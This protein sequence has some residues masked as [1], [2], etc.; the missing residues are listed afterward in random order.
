MN[1]KKSTTFL[2]L[3]L[4]FTFSCKSYVVPDKIKN[5]FTT[6]GPLCSDIFQVIIIKNPDKGIKTQAEQRES[7][8][9]STRNNIQT[10]CV[11][12]MFQFYTEQKK[13]SETQLSIETVS[14]IRE[15]FTSIAEDYV[16]EQEY[17]LEDNSA[18]LII[19][20]YQN[21]IINKILNY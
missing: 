11:N 10:E 1:Y 3:L 20:I 9:N 16:I 17:Y 2:F 6:R 18:V 4:L 12:Q 21:D 14:D 7:A 5:N 8:F 19:R 15:H 13:I